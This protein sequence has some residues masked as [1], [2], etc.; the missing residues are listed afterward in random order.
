MHALE[1]VTQDL[2]FALRAMRRNASSTL[3]AIVTLGLGIGA[4]TAMFSVVDAVLLRPLPFERPEQVVLVSPTIE[5]WRD[6][7]SLSAQ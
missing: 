7:P 5:K 4:S 2:K 3:L 1:S 6:H